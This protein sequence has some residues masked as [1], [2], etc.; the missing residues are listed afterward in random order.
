MLKKGF[1]TVFGGKATRSAGRN[2]NDFN[3]WDSG[4]EAKLRPMG[5]FLPR[6]P[7]FSTTC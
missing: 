1:S 4:F 5:Q 7:T 2:T 3:E 6:R